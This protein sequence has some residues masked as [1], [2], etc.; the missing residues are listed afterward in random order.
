MRR[1][2]PS[3]PPQSLRSI[4][5][6]VARKL[7]VAWVLAQAAACTGSATNRS[8]S[9]PAPQATGE[10][11]PSASEASP[12]VV[13]GAA[14]SDNAVG[15]ESE[16]TAPAPAASAAPAAP[17]VYQEPPAVVL[18]R[19][20]VYCA[21]ESRFKSTVNIVSLLSTSEDAG[22]LAAGVEAEL[23]R[24]FE[25][26]PKLGDDWISVASVVVEKVQT[27]GSSVARNQR[28]LI[29]LRI[30]EE[31]PEARQKGKKSPFLRGAKVRLQVD[32]RVVG[33]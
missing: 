20:H 17:P 9:Q 14:A 13:A 28:Q 22:L 1:L 21:M 23:Q 29:Q 3:R 27:K 31:Q 7:L 5:V 10:R 2:S 4:F 30:I 25:P 18:R 16:P 6:P 11:S 26:A 12:A 19:S 33:T 15:A 8:E 24:K 32:R